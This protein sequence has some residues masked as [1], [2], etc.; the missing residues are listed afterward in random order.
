MTWIARVRAR[1]ERDSR[2]PPSRRW[3]PRVRTR[4]GELAVPRDDP[5]F[6]ER[7]AFGF[8]L[9]HRD[10]DDEEAGELSDVYPDGEEE[11]L[12]CGEHE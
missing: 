11:P 9:I 2:R 1:G 12:A 7:L 6:A 4:R 5:D 8:A 10:D 3:R